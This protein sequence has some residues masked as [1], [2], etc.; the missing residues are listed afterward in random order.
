MM[1]SRENTSKAKVP[2]KLGP[3]PTRLRQIALVV[4]D[5]QQARRELVCTPKTIPIHS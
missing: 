2:A 5:L 4:K 1:P 3:A